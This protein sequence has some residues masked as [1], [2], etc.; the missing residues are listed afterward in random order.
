LIGDMT[1]PRMDRVLVTGCAGF[2]GSHLSERLIDD[3]VEVVG[4]DC[5]TDFYPRSIKERNLSRLLDEASFTLVERDL[6]EDRL[7]GLLE[8][9][10]GVFHLAA[11]P[12]VRGSFGSTFSDYARHNI[13]ATQALLEEASRRPVDWFV[14]ASSS[15]VYGDTP[16]FPTR[17]GSELRPVSPYGMTKLATEQIA[18]VYHRTEGVP[19]VGL[20]YFTAY[21]P[22]Q[23]PDMALS[24][25][26]RKAISKEPLPILG[27]G[28]QIRDF[29]FVSDIVEGT[30]AAAR[31]E[32]GSVYNIGGGHAI[33]LMRLVEILEELL[34]RPLEI[35]RRGPQRGDAR[36]TCSDGSKAASE[37]GFTPVCDLAEGMARQLE[38]T[39]ALDRVDVRTPLAT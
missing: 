20:R 38:W 28:R 25:F 35:E 2:L 23:R 34:E 8:D 14:Y 1:K 9:V 33:E 16:T 11:Q 19:V 7:D 29:T 21:G 36:Q 18:S 3:G 12:G 30:I 27:D 5:F 17:E 13:Q 37:L 26:L 39:L 10:S 4:V 22:R 24:R 32:A 31:G 6:S 15:S